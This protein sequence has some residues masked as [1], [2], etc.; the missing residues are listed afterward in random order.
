METLLAASGSERTVTDSVYGKVRL[1][2][3]LVESARCADW[4]RFG[5]EAL[6]LHLDELDANVLAF[7]IDAYQRRLIV[8]K[9]VA[10]DAN[11]KENV[12]AIGWQL[13]DESVLVLVLDRLKRLGVPVHEGSSQ[14][15]QLRGVERYW[16]FVGPKRQTIEFFVEPKFSLVPL[17]M[18]NRHGFKT[19]AG[20]MG[21]LAISSRAPRAMLAMWQQ[22]FDA[23]IS[24]YIDEHID[25]VNLELTF[26]R[27]N[28]RHHSVAIAATRGMALNPLRTMIHHL[29]FE[30]EHFDDV[31]AGY[32][33]CRELGFK[34]ANGI[35]QHPNDRE[36]S[37]YAVSP[38]DFEIELG[39]NPIIVPDEVMQADQ[40]TVFQG[41]SLW[42]H[43]PESLTLADRVGRVGR[44]VWSL[45]RLEFN[46]LGDHYV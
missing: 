29:N 22:V 5:F 9:G 34:I 45:T 28:E 46:C 16:Y 24:D 1:G 6:G 21:H 8:G 43:F 39:W 18:K 12:A 38:S 44:G 42:G 31:V 19:G 14:G 35:G 37:F 36:L 41:I 15:A 4:R 32:R 2:Y 27:L 23:R 3:V 10:Q 17:S 26:L 40:P 30:T 20:G 13:D 7:R 25:G 11:L 33:R